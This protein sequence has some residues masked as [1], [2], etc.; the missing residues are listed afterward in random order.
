MTTT[1]DAFHLAG[2]ATRITPEKAAEQLAQAWHHL[3]THPLS[4]SPPEADPHLYA[5]Y[6][7]YDSDFRGPYTFVLGVRA[8]P[9]TRIAGLELVSVPRGPFESFTAEGVPQQTL[10]KTWSE[11]WQRWPAGAEGRRYAVDFERYTPAALAALAKH[12]PT[13]VDVFVGLK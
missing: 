5:A 8:A 3:M 13:R 12:Q 2:Y 11:V 9:S 6:T 4:I 7:Q 1:F 10:W